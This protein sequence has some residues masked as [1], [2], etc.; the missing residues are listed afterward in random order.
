MQLK[1]LLARK[2]FDWGERIA[3]RLATQSERENAVQ[4]LQA[5]LERLERDRQQVADGDGA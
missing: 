1:L 3:H 5:S 2:L 4:A